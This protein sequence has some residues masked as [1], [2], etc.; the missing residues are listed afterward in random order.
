MNLR[1]SLDE[2]YTDFETK[3][4]KED[5]AKFEVALEDFSVLVNNITKDHQDKQN[6]LEEYIRFYSNF[7]ALVGKLFS[8]CNLI[9]SVDTKNKV[10]QNNLEELENK[11]T[12]VS[13]PSAKFSKWLGSI[14]NLEELINKSHLLSQ[15]QF[16]LKEMKAKSKYV[17]DEKTEYILAKL[18]NTG[19]N[20]WGKL[21]DLL[22]SS[23]LVDIN[24]AGEDKKL[25]L[26]VIRNMA[27]DK[28]GSVR[29]KAYEA[30]LK[31]YEKVEDSVA[32]ALSSIKGESLTTSKLRG[33]NSILEETLINSRMDRESLDAMLAAIKE[34]LPAFRKFYRKKA[35]L[36]GHT[37]G[38]PFYELFAPMGTTDMSYTYE[39]ARDFINLNF[40]TFS[41]KLADYAL[42]AFNNRWIDAEPREGK[43]GG[44]FCSNIHSIKE[45]RIMSNFSGSFSDVVTLSHELGHGYH[46]Y[47][48]DEETE[49]NSDYPMP[50]AET[51]STFCETIVKKAAIKNGSKEE[52]FTILEAELSDCG[53]V[54]VDIYSR[55]IFETKLFEAREKNSVTAEELKEIMLEAQKEAY[56][57]GLDENV[58][59]PYMW[60]CKPH[61]YY[62]D[63]HFYN[64]PYAFG[65]LFSKGLYAE[66][67]KK[68]EAFVKDYDKLLSVTGKNNLADITQLIGIDIHDINFWR[69]SLKIV[70][71]DIE[72]FISL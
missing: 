69:S 61:Y 6:K 26:T 70:E 34:Y 46:G 1:W 30:E 41:D 4:F 44:A 22:T 8:Y 33:Y 17:L 20:S 2:L 27:Y 53:Q 50:I 12:F 63:A 68:G 66:Y 13:E 38:L 3:E 7:S 48:L 65:V 31:A 21:K 43:V 15:H 47:C 40:R 29:K 62:T 32:A 23:L 57:D 58:L 55:Y 60:L 16:Y 18:K 39:E 24:L 36:L 49:L 59:H 45:S 71:E 14:D 25:P 10:A 35:E 72:T 54:I 67:L 42:K 64:F 28:D 5:I 52:A 11:I 56:G 9:T 19:S 51:A 37:S